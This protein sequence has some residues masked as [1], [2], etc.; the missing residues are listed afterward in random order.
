[1]CEIDEHESTN[2]FAV[3][4]C[5]AFTFAR[6]QPSALLAAA[7]QLRC[8][9]VCEAEA[10]CTLLDHAV[11]GCIPW[12]NLPLGRFRQRPIVQFS[13]LARSTMEMGSALAL[14]IADGAL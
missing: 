2:H 9:K 13:S 6:A 8:R 11:Q 5:P 7:A 10:L 12:I 4:R 3:A 14:R 1:M